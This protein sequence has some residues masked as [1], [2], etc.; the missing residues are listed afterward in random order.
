MEWA[1]ADVNEDVLAGDAL[2]VREL[3]G[4]GG[5]VPDGDIAHRDLLHAIQA[6]TDGPVPSWRQL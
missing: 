5:H 1:L 6:D 3:D 4:E 2:T